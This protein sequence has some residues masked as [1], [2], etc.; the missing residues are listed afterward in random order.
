[1]KFQ[2]AEKDIHCCLCM[3]DC[4]P[5]I[6]LTCQEFK[7]ADINICVDCLQKAQQLFIAEGVLPCVK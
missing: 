2:L 6:Y 7:H 5:T 1:M 4:L 3:K